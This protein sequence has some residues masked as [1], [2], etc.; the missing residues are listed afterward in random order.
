[1]KTFLPIV[2]VAIVAGCGYSTASLHSTDYSSVAVD[3]FKNETFDRQ[4]EFGLAEALVK[5]IE[6]KTPWKV[7]GRGK[8]DTALTGAIVDFERRVLTKLPDDDTLELQVVLVVDYTWKDLKSG[9][10]LRQGRLRQPGEAVIAVDESEATA[11]REAFQDIAE[12]I[13]EK[14]E[15]SW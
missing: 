7:T 5:E 9:K 11:A 2:L 14:M 4:I 12:R 15:Q 10:V 3:I 1:M 13:V 8:A 6:R